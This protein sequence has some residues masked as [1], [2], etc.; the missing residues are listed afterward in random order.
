LAK[1]RPAGPSAGV[2]RIFETARTPPIAASAAR[3]VAAGEPRR[4]RRFEPKAIA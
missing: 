4:L 1:L 2:V 3:N